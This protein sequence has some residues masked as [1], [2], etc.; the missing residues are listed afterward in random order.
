MATDSPVF[1]HARS[2]MGPALHRLLAAGAAP[3]R[4]ATASTGGRSCV[5][6]AA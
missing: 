6:W 3:V 4:S 2:Q 1:D 5:R